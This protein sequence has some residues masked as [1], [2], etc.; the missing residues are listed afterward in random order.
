MK[1]NKIILML[2]I[3]SMLALI[4]TPVFA[5]GGNI[6]ESK[7][8]VGRKLTEIGWVTVNYIPDGLVIQ[9]SILGGPW[10]IVETHLEVAE[11]L[12][13]IPQT[14]KG[15]PKVGHFE[16]SDEWDMEKMVTYE[17]TIEGD[18]FWIAAHAVVYNED[19]GKYETAWGQ[20]DNHFNFPGNNWAVYFTF[21]TRIPP[22]IEPTK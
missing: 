18:D 14:K 3:I 6:Y 2:T 9:Y 20:G 17:I 8:V 12:D 13:G 1:F 15:N 5:G 11:S 7:L 10:S 19:T 16:Y 21:P 22:T 4:V